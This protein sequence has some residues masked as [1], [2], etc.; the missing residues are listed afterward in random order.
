M[1]NIV[2]QLRQWAL[3]ASYNPLTSYIQGHNHHHNT[4]T[5][6]WGIPSSTVDWCEP[7]Y[8]YTQYIAEFFNTISS[9][10][11]VFVGLLGIALHWRHF[12]HRFKWAFA[13]VAIVGLGSA[14]FHGTLLFGLQMADELPMIYS[15][16]IL[17]YCVIQQPYKRPRYGPYLPIAMTIHALIATVLVASPALAPQYASPTLQ[18]ISFHVSFA[19][20][21]IFLLVKATQFWLAEKDP[22]MRRLHLTGSLLWLSGIIC[23]LLDYA[24]CESLWEGPQ[25]LRERYLVWEVSSG[26][27]IGLPNPQLHSWWHVCASAGLYL[28]A[29][30]VAQNRAVVLGR[31]AVIKYRF[32]LVPYV[33]LGD[34]K[35][36]DKKVEKE[37]ELKDDGTVLL[38]VNGSVR[39]RKNSGRAGR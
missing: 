18:F 24:G 22:Q 23:W 27:R 33:Y 32:G 35:R 38:N 20:L 11:M 36:Q 26:V 15:S 29:L 9:F 37:A 2:Q 25:S 1:A 39:Q 6:F 17:A 7:N 4:R 16:L 3:S 30:A 13:S 14:A 5:G 31:R 28:M 34:L 10:A 19:L 8:V 21:E 12:E